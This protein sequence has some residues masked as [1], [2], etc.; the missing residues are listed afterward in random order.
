ML[1]KNVFV[2]RGIAWLEPGNVVLKGYQTEERQIMQDADFVRGLR[3]RLGQVLSSY[4]PAFPCSRFA[5]YSKPDEV[6][7]AP[8][9]N[10][11]PV[12]NAR[13][14]TP[15]PPVPQSNAVRSPL[16][17]IDDPPSPRPAAGP[18]DVNYDDDAEQP[19]RRKVPTRQ[20][21]PS[22]VPPPR[23]ALTSSRFFGESTSGGSGKK[24]AQELKLSPH[25]QAPVLVPDSDEERPGPSQKPPAFMGSKSKEVVV[26]LDDDVM[27]EGNAPIRNPSPRSEDFD[28]DFEWDGELLETLD[29]AEKKVYGAVVD[30][31]ANESPSRAPSGDLSIIEIDD[32]E[33]Q[34]EKEN[35][36]VPT[37]HVRRRIVDDDDIIELSD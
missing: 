25:R 33:E 12:A 34:E 22:P 37:R 31:P 5:C 28:F 27:V 19:R 21:S 14:R 18:S 11:A 9:Q 16:L 30:R 6:P 32:D 20:R 4:H 17:P 35:V 2:R 3:Q 8:V 15:P 29:N 1:L 7:A 10:V 13:V 24:L 26:H 23:Q 36:P